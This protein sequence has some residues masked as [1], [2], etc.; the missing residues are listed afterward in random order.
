M[1][2]LMPEDVNILHLFECGLLALYMYAWNIAET[3]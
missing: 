3:A 1:R 2:G